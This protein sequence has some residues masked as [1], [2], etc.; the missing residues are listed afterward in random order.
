LFVLVPAT[1]LHLFDHH[2][3]LFVL[4]YVFLHS[5]ALA[6][7]FACLCLLLP[8]F[9]LVPTHLFPLGCILVCTG[10]RYLIMFI[11]PLFVLVC[12]LMGLCKLLSLSFV[13]VSNQEGS[14]L[15]VLHLRLGGES[16]RA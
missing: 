4:I 9:M 14:R 7:I 10:P 11:W 3:C 15:K 2:S 13:S 5:F 12:A 6:L 16:L 8:L 1:W